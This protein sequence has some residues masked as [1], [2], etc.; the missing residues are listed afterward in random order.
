M[1][2][3]LIQ[4]LLICVQIQFAGRN[5]HLPHFA[6]NGVTIHVGFGI[7]IKPVGLQLGQRVVKCVP[8][9]K[10]HVVE[11]WLMLGQIDFLFGLSLELDLVGAL[12]DTVGGAC[13]GDVAR[14]ERPLQRDLAWTNIGGGYDG[15]NHV[16]DNERQHH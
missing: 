7:G 6:F 5:Q 16:A 14:D 13:G 4:P 3:E 12:V 15:G 2:C 8:V 11:Q 9:P 10:A 1:K